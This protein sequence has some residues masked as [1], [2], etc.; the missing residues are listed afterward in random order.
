MMEKIFLKIAISIVEE[1]VTRAK[2][3]RSRRSNV[4]IKSWVNFIKLDAKRGFVWNI[5]TPMVTLKVTSN[6][7]RREGIM[8]SEKIVSG[9][10]DAY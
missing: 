10:K 2:S 8:E 9:K 4:Q 6:E 1:D 5:P 7:V 3:G